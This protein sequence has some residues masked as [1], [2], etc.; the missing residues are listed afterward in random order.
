MCGLVFGALLKTA[1]TAGAADPVTGTLRARSLELVD[2]QGRIYLRASAEVEGP[3]LIMAST[4][5]ADKRVV[6]FN[7]PPGY[8]VARALLGIPD[9][10]SVALFGG[11]SEGRRCGSVVVADKDTSVGMLAFGS[12]IGAWLTLVDK[13]GKPRDY[14]PY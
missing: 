10:G 6:V 3:M 9:E 13:Y 8:N 12:G 7:I 14:I 2:A 1:T 5:P 4:A 11:I